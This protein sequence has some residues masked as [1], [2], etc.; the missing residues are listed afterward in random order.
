VLPGVVGGISLLLA[1]YAFSVLPVNLAGL[2]LIL[3]AIL[4]FVAEIKVVSHGLLSV[5]GAIALI[6]GSLLLFSGQ[7]DRNGYRVDLGII[8]PGIAVT[9]AVVGLLSFKTMQLRML[10]ARTGASAMLGAAARVVDGFDDGRGRVQIHGEYW[11][12]S[13]PPGLARGD[14]VTVTRVEGMTLA[15]ERRVG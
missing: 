8:V 6:A 10:P 1:L 4:L 9:L 15:V 11:E 2:G 12:A 3:F 13:G 14:L 7:G 5:G